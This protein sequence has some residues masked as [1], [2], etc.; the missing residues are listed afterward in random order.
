MEENFRKVFVHELGHFISNWILFEEINQYKPEK[1]ELISKD[2]SNFWGKLYC[3]RRTDMPAKRYFQEAVLYD[4]ES[5]LTTLYGCFFQSILEGKSSFKDC[6]NCIDGILDN[7]F[8]ESAVRIY[9]KDYGKIEEI[10]NE[11]FTKLSNTKLPNLLEKFNIE[12]YYSKDS[13]IYTFDELK[14]DEQIINIKEQIKPIFISTYQKLK[15]TP[16]K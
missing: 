5:T 13:K 16:Q 14:K 3:K 1:I 7:N 6:L 15:T 9:D 8:F 4:F 10:M 2:E 12:E 11:H